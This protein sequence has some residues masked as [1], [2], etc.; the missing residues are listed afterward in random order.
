MVKQ[1]FKNKK[2]IEKQ[3]LRFV[4]GKSDDE[5]DSN[6]HENRGFICEKNILI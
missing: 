2:L 6:I 3:N 1:K 4:L 5:T